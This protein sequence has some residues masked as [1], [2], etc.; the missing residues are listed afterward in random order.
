MSTFI[1]IPEFLN[2]AWVDMETMHFHMAQSALL[3]RTPMKIFPGVHGK[4][5]WPPD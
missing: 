5:N 4:L 3:F 1:D 2:P